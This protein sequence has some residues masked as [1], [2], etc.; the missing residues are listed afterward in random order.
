MN[1]QAAQCGALDRFP[2]MVAFYCIDRYRMGQLSS[3]NMTNSALNLHR[4]PTVLV[5]V[6][7][8]SM[9]PLLWPIG[10]ASIHVS[11]MAST[12][13]IPKSILNSH[14]EWCTARRY[15]T[16]PHWTRSIGKVWMDSRSVGKEKS[17]PKRN[18]CE[19]GFGNRGRGKMG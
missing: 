16:W 18:V 15:R 7:Y 14:D 6:L 2:K 19:K 8:H 5:L 3:T 10:A 13:A 12:G 17:N 1:C 11:G 9:F 4:S